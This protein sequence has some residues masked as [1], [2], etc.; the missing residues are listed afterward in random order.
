[1][2]MAMWSAATQGSP[3]GR[4][5]GYKGYTANDFA[6][7]FWLTMVVGHIA[8]AWDVYELGYFVQSGKLSSRL[9]RPVLPVW[10][11]VADNIAYKVVSLGVLVP[12][13]IFIVILT[14]P[15]FGG[16]WQ[17]F[18]VSVPIIILAAIINY[19]WCYNVAMLAFWFT[20]MDA[21]G[22]GWFGFGLL[23]GGRLAPL[24]I[25]P[26]PLRNIASALPFKYVIWFPCE[27][28][29][30]RHKWP[31]IQGD[32]INQVV[33]IITGLVVFHIMWRVGVKR[34]S[35]VGA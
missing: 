18:L 26:K 15:H 34:Y 19:I 10:Q 32:M 23:F 11:S 6:A 3:S 28:L 35:A 8:T 31:A 27:V 16:N 25:M 21:I 30:G 2:S 5:G 24:L 1:V 14:R 7:Y 9:L 17:H 22:Q 29:M 20:R 12:I 4:L 13:W 33:W